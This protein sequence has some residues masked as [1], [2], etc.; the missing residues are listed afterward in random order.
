MI[1]RRLPDV[2]HIPMDSLR[3]RDPELLTLFDADTRDA[4]IKAEKILEKGDG[5]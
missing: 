2:K 5:F 4:M 3:E 1:L